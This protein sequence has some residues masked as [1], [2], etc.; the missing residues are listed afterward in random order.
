ML[1]RSYDRGVSPYGV[2]QMAGNA[3]EWVSDWF[4]TDYYRQASN[5]NPAGPAQGE[6]KVYR[7]GSWNEDPEV[8]R[9]A[10]RGAHE[11]AH[12]SYLIGFRC[13]RDAQR[14]AN[15]Q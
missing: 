2:Y 1:F 14:V 8:A 4:L 11:P 5:E 12:R 7:G 6:M 3:A 15:G 9:S 13:A 10:G